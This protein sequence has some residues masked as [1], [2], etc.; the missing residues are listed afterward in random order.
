MQRIIHRDLKPAN[1]LLDAEGRPRITDFGL[2]RKL[3][4]AGQTVTGAVLGTPSYMAPEQAAG[5]TREVGPLADVYALGAILY[6]LLTGRPPFKA[7]TALETL[8]LVRATEPVAPRQLQPKAPHDLETICLKCLHKIPARRYGSALELAEDLKRFVDGEPI[9]ARPVGR[10]ERLWRW[11]RRQP[12]AAGLLGTLVLV[13]AGGLSGLTCLWLL[14]EKHLNDANR[15]WQRANQMSQRTYRILNDFSTQV[16]QRQELK[17]YDLEMLR[18]EWLQRARERYDELVQDDSDPTL[19]AARGTTYRELAGLTS[20]I[21]SSSEAIR[22]AEQAQEMLEKLV[23]AHAGVPEH[24]A[25]LA[26]AHNLVGLLYAGSGRMS[27]AEAAYRKARNLQ[28]QL[29]REQ[30]DNTSFRRQLG[31]YINNLGVLYRATGRPRQAREAYEEARE[32]FTSLNRQHPGDPTFAIWLAGTCSNLGNIYGDL[33]D[34]PM[35]E[36]SHQKAVAIANEV[37]RSHPRVP[38]HQYRQGNFVNNLGSFYLDTGRKDLARETFEK[39]LAIR[40]KLTA[41][42]PGVFAYQEVVVQSTNNVALV[43]S[44]TGLRE[45]ARKMYEAS[46]ELCASLVARDDTIP[47]Y[48]SLLAL[49]QNNLGKLH[50]ESRRWEEAEAAYWKVMTLRQ[51]LV[52]EDPSR[53]NYA[54][55]LAAVY[56]SL[57]NLYNDRPAPGRDPDLALEAYAAAIEVLGPLA[58]TAELPTKYQIPLKD[59]WYNRAIVL[60]NEGQMDKA[61]A[62]YREALRLR[63]VLVARHANDLAFALDLGKA[64]GHLGQVLA[65]T[66]DLPSALMSYNAAV[67]RLEALLSHQRFGSLARDYLVQALEGRSDALDRTGRGREA[68][69]DLDRAMEVDNN[70]ARKAKLMLVRGWILARLPK[71]P[72]EKLP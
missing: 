5:K 26:R 62:S 14:A 22:L 24:R 60:E 12:L 2:A 37:V 17:S 47:Q 66:G 21:G 19:A 9:H 51:R 18:K 15:E 32:I 28:E 20:E 7:A 54:A 58:E 16:S 53:Q 25:E 41:E 48:R 6:E 8:V 45:E 1:V 13:V 67:P 46:V 49:C 42:H 36:A 57:G 30:E 27:A 11:C 43:L 56:Y 34:E 35:A 52:Q 38:E 40:Q 44:H 65:A 55:D 71:Q 3:D 59:C 50:F 64:Q 23:E 10:A 70:W 61:L 72:P 63:E 68:L 4:E 29:V 33:R 39:A 31:V 69:A